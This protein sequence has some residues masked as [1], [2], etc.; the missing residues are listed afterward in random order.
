MRSGGSS[1]QAASRNFWALRR[2]S[3]T[4]TPPAKRSWLRY[5]ALRASS[6]SSEVLNMQVFVRRAGRRIAPICLA[7]PLALSQSAAVAS[8][9][10]SSSSSSSSSS[11]TSAGTSGATTPGGGSQPGANQPG[12]AEKGEHEKGETKPESGAKGEKEVGATKP[13]SGVGG[14]REA[15]GTTPGSARGGEQL[16][17]GSQPATA[18][19]GGGV[20][21]TPSA[22][23]Q[24]GLA[25]TGLNIWPIGLLGALLLGSSFAIVRSARRT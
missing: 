24:G 20:G 11:A 8:G 3:L 13:Q 17:G 10:P 1:S 14:E 19:G 15:G 18:P 21:S 22:G 6:P 9:E 16:A 7:I 25:S 2:E 4:D 23:S 12:S 5:G